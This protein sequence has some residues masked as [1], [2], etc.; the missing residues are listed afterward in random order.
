[1]VT[2]QPG[3]RMVG[4]PRSVPHAPMRRHEF[5]FWQTGVMECRGDL[6]KLGPT[7]ALWLQHRRCK[8]E[9]GVEFRPTRRHFSICADGSASG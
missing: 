5:C 7:P 4:G 8:S 1:M 6:V 9:N 2:R 3:R